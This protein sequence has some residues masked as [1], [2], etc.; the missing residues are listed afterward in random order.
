MKKE[1]EQFIEEFLNKI[2]EQGYKAGQE[3]VKRIDRD[4][5]DGLADGR[6]EAW[7][8]ARKISSPVDNGGL[9]Q[10]ELQEVFG[11]Y[12]SYEVYNNFSI[13]EAL[14]RIKHFE[15]R[16]AKKIKVGDEVLNDGVDHKYRGVV[17]GLEQGVVKILWENYNVTEWK[18]SSV[19]KI[20]TGKNYPEL[21]EILKTN[22]E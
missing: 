12:A 18:A 11:Y 20:K 17:I 19:E 2:Y 13:T 3:S 10:K 15:E 1:Y 8:C 6:M 7:A 9:T 4:Y 5:Q 16:Q 22:K 14:D 21:E